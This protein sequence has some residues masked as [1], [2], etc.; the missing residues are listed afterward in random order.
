ME[1]LNLAGYF[2]AYLISIGIAL[3]S[4]IIVLVGGFDLFNLLHGKKTTH[5]SN[6][7]LKIKLEWL[8]KKMDFKEI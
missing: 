3:L 7:L 6:F 2:I 8:A 4:L 1:Y 5:L